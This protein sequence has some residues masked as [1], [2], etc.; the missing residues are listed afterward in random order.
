MMS[1][2]TKEASTGSPSERR[3]YPTAFAERNRVVIGI[4][5]LAA[6][7][8][9]FFATYHVDDLPVIGGGETHQAYLAETAGLRP[10]NEVR[11]AGVKVGE[12]TDVA[13]SGATVLVTFRAKGVRLGDQTTAAVKIK[14]MLGQKFLAIAPLGTSALDGPIPLEQTTTPYD[15]T[16][17][18]SDLSDNVEEIDTAQ[19]E[20][21]L[22]TLS[23]VFAETPESVR[24]MVS[25]L[26]RLSRTVSSRDAELDRLF[27]ATTDVTGVVAGRNDELAALI[28]DGE[29]LLD[30]L[31][32]RRE[33]IRTMLRSTAELG[34]QVRALV[35]ENEAQLRPA[36]RQLDR[37]SDLLQR[38]QKHLN[39]AFEALGPY[40][41]MLADAM[42]NGR[43][44]D[45]YIC[46]LFDDN[47]AP[48]LENDVV[49]DCRPGG[50]R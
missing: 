37:V 23:T 32:A 9:T 15:V 19:L 41:R 30:E 26:S 16:A 4:I 33:S 10:G 48:V 1:N 49:R 45:S 25:G 44:V 34:R 8:A 28:T 6:L 14:T 50:K 11:V 29:L 40:Y 18:F 43:W 2:R 38:N 22:D 13:L 5:G 3:R 24:G 7:V 35:K 42:G 12:V 46:G 31:A 17:A 20:T 27:E 47:N 36:L 39:Q 21:S